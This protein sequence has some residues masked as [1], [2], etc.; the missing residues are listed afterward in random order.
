MI[1]S[2]LSSSTEYEVRATATSSGGT[3]PS[4]AILT[5]ST[6]SSLP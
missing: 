2:G 5:V 3:S 1:I 4:S 6:G